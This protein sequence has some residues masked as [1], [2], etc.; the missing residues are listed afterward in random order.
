MM[1]VLQVQEHSNTHLLFSDYSIKFLAKLAFK[2]SLNV[3]EVQIRNHYISLFYLG[4]SQ[5]RYRLEIFHILY[6]IHLVLMYMIID[7]AHILL[8]DNLHCAI[9]LLVRR[10]KKLSSDH[11][12][13]LHNFPLSLKVLLLLLITGIM[14]LLS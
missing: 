7:M 2:T 3:K 12:A 4:T 8:N 11:Q 6:Q 10:V 13:L 5:S 1:K 9:L 14:Q